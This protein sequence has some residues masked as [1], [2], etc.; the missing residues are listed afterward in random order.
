MRPALQTLIAVAIT[1]VV[2]IIGLK[3][4]NLVVWGLYS[5]I[6]LALLL[7]VGIFLYQVI[8]KALR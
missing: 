8:R 2:M 6:K 5:L 1:I 7:G 4:L 3:V